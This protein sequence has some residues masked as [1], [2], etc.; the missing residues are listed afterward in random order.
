MEETLALRLP[1]F[2]RALGR[3]RE[4]LAKPEDSI[5]RDACIQRFEFTF[6]MA[7]KTV[8]AY[9][10]GEGIECMSPRDCFRAAFRLALIENDPGWMAMIED[11]NRA[12]HTY[13]E[14]SAKLIY[15][16]LPNYARLLEALLRRLQS[17][18][19]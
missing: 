16:A 17:P 18:R 12:S 11:R 14:E 19:P 9:A 7:W 2:G 4:A 10:L 15:Q 1:L 6:E 8:Q 5:V 13:D 3:L